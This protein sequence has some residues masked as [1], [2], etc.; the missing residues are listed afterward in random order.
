[1][2]GRRG[3]RSGPLRKFDQRRESGPR[4]GVKPCK[5]E[6]K[7]CKKG[8]RCKFTHRDS[9]VTG[10]KP[11]PQRAGQGGAIRALLNQIV[12]GLDIPI[13]MS[14]LEKMSEADRDEMTKLLATLINETADKQ[15]SLTFYSLIFLQCHAFYSTNIYYFVS[16]QHLP[17]MWLRGNP[18]RH[19]RDFSKSQNNSTLWDFLPFLRQMKLKTK[20]ETRWEIHAGNNFTKLSGFWNLGREV[21]SQV[22]GETRN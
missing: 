10:D 12:S 16:S 13:L 1:M 2:G 9:R 18:Y 22:S 20:W 17:T 5:F 21:V 4:Q 3:R 6:K 15:V 8:R 7:N 11:E 19:W 14:D